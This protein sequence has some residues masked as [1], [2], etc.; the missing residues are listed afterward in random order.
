M[1]A[2]APDRDVSW[3]VGAAAAAWLYSAHRLVDLAV[4]LRQ[5]GTAPRRWQPIVDEQRALVGLLFG[6]GS[7]VAASDGDPGVMTR[8]DA[9]VAALQNMLDAADGLDPIPVA[10]SRYEVARAAAKAAIEAFASAT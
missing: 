3:L 10:V 7:R 8:L 2:D 9:A 6:A 4:E 5:A 1:S